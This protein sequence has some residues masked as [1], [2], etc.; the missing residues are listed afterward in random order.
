MIFHNI[1]MWNHATMTLTI[2]SLSWSCFVLITKKLSELKYLREEENWRSLSSAMWCRGIKVTGL[3][4]L[5]ITQRQCG[6]TRVSYT[7]CTTNAYSNFL[8]ISTTMEAC[9]FSNKLRQ[10]KYF[11][12]LFLPFA[13]FRI[14]EKFFLKI[15]ALLP[16]CLTNTYNKNKCTL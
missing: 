9:F 15:W 10:I 7:Q 11:S 16:T 12:S 13:F 1:I 14:R 4:K 2:F 6:P 8:V 5:S 3:G